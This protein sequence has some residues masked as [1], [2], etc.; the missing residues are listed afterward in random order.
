M[1]AQGY[2]LDSNI[3]FQDNQSA[4]KMESN[5]RA[6]CSDRSRH[7]NIRY[8]FIKDYVK[9]NKIEIKYCPTGKMLADYFTKPLQRSLFRKFRAIIMGWEPLSSLQDA[10]N[11]KERVENV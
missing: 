11:F 3:I 6:S 9:Q 1:E 10:D 8:F 7:I 4:I 2:K 5:G